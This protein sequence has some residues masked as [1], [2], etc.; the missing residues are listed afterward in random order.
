MKKLAGLVIILA[1][2][3]LG[4]YYGM[5][6]LTEKTIKK[7]IKILEQSNGVR[8]EIQN[9]DRGLYSADA[10]IK[11]NLHI[12]ARQ[13]TDANGSNQTIPAQD[14]TMSMPLKIYHGPIIYANG[15]LRFGLGYAE[16]VFPF[17]HEYNAEFDSNFSSQS[18]KPQLNLSIFVNYLN[19][20]TLDSQVPAF[21][22]FSKQG[23]GRFDWL[24]MN[25]TTTMSSG[26]KKIR[27]T[28]TFDGAHLSKEDV[29][30]DLGKVSSD[31]DL[32]ETLS[33]LYLGDANLNLPSFNMVA[34]GEKLFEI[35]DLKLR[36]DSDIEQH[37]FNSNFTLSIKS[38]FANAKNYGPGSL[39]V[40]LRNIDADVLARINQQTN[41]M[42]NGT[43]IQRQQAIIALLPELPKLFSKGAEFEISK[44]NLVIPQGTIEGNLFVSLPREDNANP[45][46]LMQKMQGN[47]KLR[48][49]AAAIKE[50]MERSVL[51][52]IAKQPELKQQLQANQAAATP[53]QA[54]L[55][56][57]QLASAQADKQLSKL[58]QNGLIMVQGTDYLVEITL[59][60]GKFTVNGKPFDSSMLKF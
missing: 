11:W 9:Y 28:I 15:H 45:F 5:G 25:W 37:L 24:G 16:S 13:V 47:A 50:L 58:Q 59:S 6:I 1:A 43:E 32:H 21:K 14:Y 56:T 29:K 55:T 54:V 52:Q 53:N 8:A 60:Q 30:A 39:V 57:E 34:K 19:Q 7:N 26:L 44:L 27:G 17:P 51:Q 40:A 18:T 46:E 36:S 3:I 33:G 23:N 41:A 10:L 38:L 42:Q 12:P 22:L 20:S 48:I 49:P 2:L 4:G 31:Y 35:N